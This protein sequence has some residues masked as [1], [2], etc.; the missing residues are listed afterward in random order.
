MSRQFKVTGI[1]VTTTRAIGVTK[2]G[3]P[4]VIEEVPEGSLL[5]VDV[6]GDIFR[7]VG[8]DEL[9]TCPGADHASPYFD[10]WVN[11]LFPAPTKGFLT[12]GFITLYRD[13]WRF[14]CGSNHKA[15][16]DLAILSTPKRKLR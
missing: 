11:A 13:Y 4:Y 15:M 14:V 16:L 12:K 8:D 1:F 5:A 10:S 6:N 9:L 3:Q 7:Y 2:D